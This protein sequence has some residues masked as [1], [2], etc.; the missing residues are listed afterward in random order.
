MP[1]VSPLPCASVATVS[2]ADCELLDAMITVQPSPPGQPVKVEPV[3]VVVLSSGVGLGSGVAVPA[4]LGLGV[5]VATGLSVGSGDTVA[6]GIGLEVGT[7]AC[8]EG[9]GVGASFSPP[10][11]SAASASTTPRIASAARPPASTIGTR[12][13]RGSATS[14]DAAAPHA[15][16]HS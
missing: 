1:T 9:V 14:V 7:A 4:G 5:A 11:E 3:S 16:H 12:Q 13:P 10:P 15:R 2:A 6:L 8:G